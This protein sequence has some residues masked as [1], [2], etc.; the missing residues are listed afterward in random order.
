MT[1]TATS[2]EEPRMEIGHAAPPL[3]RALVTLGNEVELDTRLRELV[4]W[5]GLGGGERALRAG[6]TRSTGVGDHGDQRVEP[7]RDHDADAAPSVVSDDRAQSRRRS[8]S[9]GRAPSDAARRQAVQL[10][11]I[12]G[13]RDGSGR[14]G[15]GRALRR[16]SRR[17]RDHRGHTFIG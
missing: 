8:C 1:T 12:Q 6:R 4:T 11:C 7:N 14:V 2:F 5:G 17:G 13:K 9:G 16:R 10:V 15:V 3:H